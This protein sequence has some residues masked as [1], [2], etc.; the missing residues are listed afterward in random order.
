MKK[1]VIGCG[2]ALV[3]F[4]ITVAVAGYYFLLRPAL[5]FKASMT[6]LAAVADLDTALT[7]TRPF[8]PPA[9]ATLS[10]AQVQRFVAVQ[11]VVK[12]R[13]GSRFTELK[14]KYEKL[15]GSGD[16]G[17]RQIRLTEAVGA[18]QDLFGIIT[19]A[20]RAQVD[21]GVRIRWTVVEHELRRAAPQRANLTVEIH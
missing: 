12:T 8:A 1:L 13:L 7:N 4:G 18:Y 20:R 11:N 14:T 9:D 3:L 16:D 17:Q 6:E 2:L 19:E 21:A 5:A 10:P 15:D